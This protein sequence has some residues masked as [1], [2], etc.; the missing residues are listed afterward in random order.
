MGAL[1]SSRPALLPT[2]GSSLPSHHR[3]SAGGSDRS[4]RPAPRTPDGCWSRRP[5]TTAAG[6]RSVKRSSAAAPAITTDHQ[7]LLA[8]AA[9]TR[10]PRCA[11]SKT[12]AANPAGSSRSRS[13]AE[14]AA[15]CWQIATWTPHPDGVPP[16]SMPAGDPRR[17]QPR[18]HRSLTRARGRLDHHALNPTHKPS[19]GPRRRPEHPRPAH[20]NSAISRLSTR[21]PRRPRSTV[22]QRTCDEQRSWASPR[23]RA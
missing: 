21:R 9:P 19:S 12:P 18:S 3:R 5:G 23:I 4:P 1:R 14:L 20:N 2:S 7:H 17:R 11:S 10:T 6:P 13:P 15:Y 8:R 22:R 16:T